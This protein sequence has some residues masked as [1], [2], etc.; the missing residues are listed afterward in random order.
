[1]K[2][3]RLKIDVPKFG[4]AASV[5]VEDS[6]GHIKG[7]WGYVCIPSEFPGCF[8]EVKT[9]RFLIGKFEIVPNGTGGEK[10]KISETLARHYEQE[11]Y[12]CI[13][14]REV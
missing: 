1:M 13:E 6:L 10:G 8:E 7:P 3:W 4:K 9:K 14:E 12:Y 11:E 5:L 2:K